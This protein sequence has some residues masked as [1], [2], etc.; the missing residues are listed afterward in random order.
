MGNNKMQVNRE[1]VSKTVAT[2]MSSKRNY[3]TCIFAEVDNV[4]AA[5]DGYND[6]YYHKDFDQDFV[7]QIRDWLNTSLQYV[8]ELFVPEAF[9]E[10]LLCRDVI[11]DEYKR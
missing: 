9:E 5:I 11:Y 7:K 8:P 6:K 3:G 10:Y 2:K 4:R 1:P